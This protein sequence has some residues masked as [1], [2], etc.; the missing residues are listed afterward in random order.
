MHKTCLFSEI[1][2]LNRSSNVTVG[3]SMGDVSNV[4]SLYACT[5]TVDPS[6]CTTVCKD[7]IAKMAGRSKAGKKSKILIGCLQ[8]A[9]FAR[10]LRMSWRICDG[11]VGI[12]IIALWEVQ[13]FNGTSGEENHA[14]E[15][16]EKRGFN[17][18]QCFC[19]IVLGDGI[20]A[21]ARA[22]KKRSLH[23]G[24]WLREKPPIWAM[25]ITL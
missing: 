20:A 4:H 8:D 9:P 19:L 16:F 17:D 6:R 13:S 3:T 7:R 24:F 11:C 2:F 14:S 25:F 15:P 1:C 21:S 22:K 10:E 12:E 23:G 5:M 18:Q